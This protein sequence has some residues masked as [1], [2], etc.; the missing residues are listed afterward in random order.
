MQC[1]SSGHR[2]GPILGRLHV[3]TVPDVAQA[4]SS[5]LGLC[6]L[7]RRHSDDGTS[8]LMCCSTVLNKLMAADNYALIMLFQ[9]TA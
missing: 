9:Q 6:K 5:S 8:C 7:L 2:N 3:S 4:L 1:D